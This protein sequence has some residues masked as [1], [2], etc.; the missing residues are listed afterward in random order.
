MFDS[1]GTTHILNPSCSLCGRGIRK[2]GVEKGGEGVDGMR[3]RA[4]NGFCC[5]L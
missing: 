2:V 4:C 1:L 5:L 3:Q